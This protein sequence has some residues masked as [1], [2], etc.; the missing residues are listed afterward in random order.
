MRRLLGLPGL[1]SL[2]LRALRA[3]NERTERRPTEVEPGV[4][5]GG[6]ATRARWTALRAAGV[7]RVVSLFAEAS[8]DPWLTDADGVLW[9]AVPDT[10]APTPE[11]L[12]A[13]CAFLDEAR[14]QGCK[15]FIYCGSG[16]GRAPT[17]YVAWWLRRDSRDVGSGIRIVQDARPV[18]QP[19]PGQRDA[20]ERWARA[21]G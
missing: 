4:F 16:I 13:G 6:V 7:T 9:L 1:R 20:L 2:W 5:V 14:A 8:P 21:E 15:V 12:R 17:M 19:T 10:D 18:A 11:Q 3:R